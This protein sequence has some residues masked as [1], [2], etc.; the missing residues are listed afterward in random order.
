MPAEEQTNEIS[1]KLQPLSVAVD[2]LSQDPAN[3]RKHDK[4]NLDAIRA[5]LARFGQVKP[6]VVAEDGVTVIAGNGMLMA[7]QSLGWKNIAAVTTGLGGSEATAFAIADNRIAELS[8]WDDDALSKVLDSLPED[9]QEVAGFSDEELAELLNINAGDLHEDEVPSVP[10]DPITKRG[11]LILLGDH[12]LL[13]GDSTNG[14]DVARLMDGEKAGVCFTSPP[15]AQQRDYGE[16]KELVQDWDALMQGVFA[17]LPMADD[18]QVLVNL[19]L[20]HKDGEWVPYWD[21]WIEWMREQGWKRFGW[22]VWDQLTGLP[23]HWNGRLGPSFEFVFHFVTN[24][25]QPNKVKVNKTAGQLNTSKSALKGGRKSSGPSSKAFVTASHGVPDSVIRQPRH[26][27][28]TD[29]PAVFSTQFANEVISY[30]GGIEYDPFCGSGT[31]L[32]AAEQLNRRCYGMEI[33]PAYC[34]VIVQRWEGLTGKTA[35]RVSLSVV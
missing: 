17:N 28:K 8:D 22:Y 12:R 25:V 30:W 14:D 32:I 2:S 6:I 35:E 31:T 21:G 1:P 9:L 3:V 34:D 4:R 5:S 24:G 18:G 23:G 16:A 11:D 33:S 20:I 27:G 26:C 15:Y 13:C 19:G 29:H 10:K 7:A